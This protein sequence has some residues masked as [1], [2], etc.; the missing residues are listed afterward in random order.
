[1]G[2]KISPITGQDML[3]FSTRPTEYLTYD[4]LRHTDRLGF[5][6][7]HTKPEHTWG[8]MDSLLLKSCNPIA[9]I[10]TPSIF[11]T[12]VGSAIRNNADI[13]DDL[14]APVRPTIPIWAQNR[15]KVINRH[16]Q[17]VLIVWQR[18]VC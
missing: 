18:C 9:V 1:M 12:P 17:Q 15:Y 2:L 6:A 14:P 7:V 4:V 3:F 8:I 11:N 10:E 16:N 5:E 13:R